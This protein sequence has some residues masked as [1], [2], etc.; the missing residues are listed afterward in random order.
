MF[1]TKEAKRKP[2]LYIIAG[3]NGSGKTTFVKR[4]LPFYVD[5]LNFVN[6]DL[7]ASGLAPFSPEIA[8]V[9]AGK[10]MLEE[11]EKYRNQRVDF[12]FETTLAGRSHLKLLREMKEEGYKIH[13][14]FLWIRSL[15]LALKRVKERVSMGG[16]DVPAQT[17]LR[18]F[19]RGRNNLFHLYRPLLDSW[20][21]FDNSGHLPMVIAK[22]TGGVK[23]ILD[24]NLFAE[25][26]KKSEVL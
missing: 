18:R 12:A 26:T 15:E 8:A 23:T 14:F 19:N 11:I 7:I 13:L 4:F 25:I 2:N 5:C 21:L 16:H 20:M 17:I 9:K 10:L 1:K 6:A 22:E 24:D 3:P